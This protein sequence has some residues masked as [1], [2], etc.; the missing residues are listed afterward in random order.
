MIK[1]KNISYGYKPKQ[2]IFNDISL[3]V[4]S[5]I[6]GLL[7][8]NGVGKTTLI[9]LICGLLFPWKGECK[10]DNCNSAQR[11]PE[12]LSHYFFLPEEMQMP[13]ESIY[14][15]AAH[16]SVFYPHFSRKEFE[17]NLEEL[18]IDGKQKLSA[19]S[20]GQQKKAMLAY[21]LALHTPLTLLDEPTNGLDIT[22]R[23]ALKRI[24][25]RSVDDESTLLI[26]THQAHDFENL[27]DHL[28][29]LGEGKSY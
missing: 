25:S 23:Q 29:I 9:H 24:I 14:Q 17:Q 7:G 2:P 4:G 28:I 6:Y 18:H 11:S 16:H 5:G 10:I 15:F 22:S 8:E 13:T 3:E 21:A 1:I 26:S 27:L 12:L 20:Y 19:V